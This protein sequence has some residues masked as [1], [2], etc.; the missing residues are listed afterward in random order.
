MKY[1]KD[2]L[3]PLYLGL[4]SRAKKF[5]RDSTPVKWYD[6]R[7][8]KPVSNI[9]G[10]DR[11]T[12]INRVYVE[13]FLKKNSR[14]IK[15]VCCE[16][17]DDGYIKKFG[18]NVIQVEVLHYTDDN[19]K[20]TIV[21]DLTD[22]TTL[23]PNKIDCFILTHVSE[24]IYDFKSAIRGIYYMLKMGGVALVTVSGIAQISR[25]DY[26][27]WGDYYRF[28]D[29]SI[30]R[31][32]EEVFGEENVEVETYGNVLT[33]IAFLE[34]ISAEELTEEELFFKD[35]DYQVTICVKALKK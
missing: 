12:P 9:F 10:F 16:V 14:F 8:L 22:V 23:P 28:T 20:A 31:A 32:F 25:Y 34:G 3:K 35:A 11:G 5:Y 18:K 29:M 1:L 27:R 4:K 15:G 30:R 19:P 2:I 26:E 21:G 13:D 17:G 24:F 33:A 7:K 6:L